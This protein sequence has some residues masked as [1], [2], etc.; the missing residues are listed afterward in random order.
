MHQIV[1]AE[2]NVDILK[3]NRNLAMKNKEAVYTTYKY[4]VR[5]EGFDDLDPKIVFEIPPDDRRNP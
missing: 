1:D 2:V 4:T 5:I 3:A